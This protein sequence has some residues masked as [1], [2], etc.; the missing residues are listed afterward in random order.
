MTIESKYEMPED[1][2]ECEENTVRYEIFSSTRQIELIV[3]LI[4]NDLSEPYSIYTYRYFVYQWP[5]LCKLV[6]N[7]TLTFAQKNNSFI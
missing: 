6:S 1:S 5:D 2:K 7:S 4:Q 3:D